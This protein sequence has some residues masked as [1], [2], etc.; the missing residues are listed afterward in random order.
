MKYLYAFT[1]IDLGPTTLR[2]IKAT[3]SSFE[4]AW[5][6]GNTATFKKLVFW[7]KQPK[8]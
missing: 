3:F 8:K 5:E 2:K 4:K 6:T 1:L 7:K